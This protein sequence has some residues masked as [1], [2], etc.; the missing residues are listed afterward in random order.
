MWWLQVIG[1]HARTR[2]PDQ[3][4]AQEPSVQLVGRDDGSDLDLATLAA[5]GVRL[6]GRLVDLDGRTATFADD[7]PD[8]TI[9]AA[10]GLARL[11]NR[12]DGY[13]DAH[14]LSREVL[15]PEPVAP[16]PTDG[17]L[18]ALDLAAAGIE[19]VVWA[20]GFRRRYDW[21]DVPVLDARG[22]LVHRRGI[23]PSPGLYVVGL[24]FQHR[25][26]SSF[27]DGVRHDA[28]HVVSHLV[29][30]GDCAAAA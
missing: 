18:R 27:I 2:D 22:E 15:D 17:A 25:R 12:I 9:A 3:P 16:V 14:G 10:A 26:D 29:R 6:A 1:A 4:V 13:I 19:T 7:L 11:R 20:T 21:L 24:W 28:R 30:R 5:S 23:T 8:T